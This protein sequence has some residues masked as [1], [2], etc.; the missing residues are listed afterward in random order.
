LSRIK[1][2][3]KFILYFVKK[4]V[5]LEQNF[6]ILILLDMKKI[7]NFYILL[8]VLTGIGMGLCFWLRPE[9]MTVRNCVCW[10]YIAV[11]FIFFRKDVDDVEEM[12]FITISG[13]L[14]LIGISIGVL[15]GMS[16]WYTPLCAVALPALYFSLW[17][18]FFG[19]DMNAENLWKN[20]FWLTFFNYALC[21]FFI[22]ILIPMKKFIVGLL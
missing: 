6:T 10:F 18:Y 15:M 1:V 9:M 3:L 14:G 5:M 7:R 20:A 17:A 19:K 12:P 8:A 11:M 21:A 4:D 13:W 22:F 2:D 16:F